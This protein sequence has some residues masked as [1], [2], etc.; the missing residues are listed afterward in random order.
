ME[1]KGSPRPL[2]GRAGTSTWA[3]LQMLD[4]LKSGFIGYNL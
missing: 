4:Q 3:S 1:I 2:V